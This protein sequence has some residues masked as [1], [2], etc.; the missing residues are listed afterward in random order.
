[1]IV[2][3][4]NQEIAIIVDYYILRIPMNIS[5]IKKKKNLKI[6]NKSNRGYYYFIKFINIL[7]IIK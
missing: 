6:K 5:K 4:L 7:F 3:Y 1:M 2:D